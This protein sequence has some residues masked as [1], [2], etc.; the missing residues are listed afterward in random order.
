MFF[1]GGGGGVGSS[2]QREIEEIGKKD[3]QIST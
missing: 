2:C 1:E 3:G